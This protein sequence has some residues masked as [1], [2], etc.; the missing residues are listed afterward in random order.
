MIAGPSPWRIVS[1]NGE[2]F[3]VRENDGATWVVRL[4][5]R[6][7]WLHDGDAPGWVRGESE[8]RQGVLL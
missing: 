1:H 8:P 5:D 3:M 7:V 6:A 2:R 4:P